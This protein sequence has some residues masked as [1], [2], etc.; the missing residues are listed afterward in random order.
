M[1]TFKNKFVILFIFLIVISIVGGFLIF[2]AVSMQKSDGVIINLAGRQRMLIQT[3]TRDFFD[4]LSNRQII[5]AVKQYAKVTTN[6]IKAYRTYYTKNIVGKLQ[7]ELP[8]I[9]ASAD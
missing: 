8:G 7:E 3:F 6:Q 4:N 2:N 5:A 1:K 9:Q